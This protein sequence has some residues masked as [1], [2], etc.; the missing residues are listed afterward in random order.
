VRDA[1]D[2]QCDLSP[3]RTVLSTAVGAL[4]GAVLAF[5]AVGG[6]VSA[7]M[8]DAPPSSRG[9][10]A[11]GIGLITAAL[12]SVAGAAVGV[13]L[14][15]RDVRGRGVTVATV[16]VGGLPVSALGAVGTLWL[17]DQLGFLPDA[18]HAIVLAAV[19]FLPATALLGRWLAARKH[20]TA[21]TN[22]EE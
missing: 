19:V 14:G 6:L 20:R 17:I 2:E 12:G 15:L 8:A 4:A 5:Y 13:A 10:A 9:L 18:R 1:T 22:P 3:V 7:L 21:A 11:L 16:L